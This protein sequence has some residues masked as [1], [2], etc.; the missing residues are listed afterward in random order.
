[1]E[2]AFNHLYL[3]LPLCSDHLHPTHTVRWPPVLLSAD[4]RPCSAPLPPVRSARRCCMKYCITTECPREGYGPEGVHHDHC[5]SLG[6]GGGRPQR[7]EAKG[8]AVPPLEATRGRG[9]GWPQR[10]ERAPVTTRISGSSCGR[11]SLSVTGYTGFSDEHAAEH[12]VRSGRRQL[13]VRSGMT[14]P[15]ASYCHN[16]PK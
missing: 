11:E 16:L 5:L 6:R 12:G 2:L 1:M 9:R 3:I 15:G 13:P 4:G 7:R 8:V 14:K 10:P